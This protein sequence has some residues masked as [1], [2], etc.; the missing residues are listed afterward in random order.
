MMSSPARSSSSSS[1]LAFVLGGGG[2]RGAMQ[3]GALLA[4]LEAN[5][6]PDILIGTSIGA[7]NAAMVAIHGFTQSGL[8]RL[9]HAWLEAKEA[10]LLPGDYLRIAVR[11]MINT[12]G[13]ETYQEEMRAFYV[14][15][16]IRPELQFRDFQHPKLYCV[17]TDLNR[18]DTYIFGND[19]SQRVLDGVLASAA[20]PPWIPPLRLGKELLMDGGALS[21]LPIEPAMRMGAT[22]IIALDLFDPRPPDL[23]ARGFSPFIE[24]LLTSVEHRQVE[25]ELALAKSRGVPVHHWQLRYYRSIPVWDF[26]DTED[27]FQSGY[28][29]G[30]AYLRRR[31]TEIAPSKQAR[32]RWAGLRAWWQRFK[33]SSRSRQ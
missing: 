33:G 21:N 6:Q 8:E 26:R 30:K 23:E 10:D 29:Q 12:M 28:M 13:K 3:V 24:K 31:Q 4:L 27:L 15:I 9:M 32:S 14:R 16:G 11:T 5:I 2:A 18:Y 17:A 22:E 7:V 25:M 20:I 19:P 1:R